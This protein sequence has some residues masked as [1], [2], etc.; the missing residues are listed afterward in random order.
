MDR[1]QLVIYRFQHNV[2]NKFPTSGHSGLQRHQ[3]PHVAKFRVIKWHQGIG[4]RRGFGGGL[5]GAQV[6]PQ[7]PMLVTQTTF[8]LQVN[9]SKA[10]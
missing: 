10:F 8:A 6:S 5:G 1:L 4:C 2:T 7:H 9:L 3:A